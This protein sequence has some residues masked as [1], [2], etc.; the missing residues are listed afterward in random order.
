MDRKTSPI[1]IMLVE[2][3]EGDIF[4]TK[5]AFE[6]AKILNTVS[7]ASN[8]EIALDMLYKRNGHEDAQTPDLIFLDINLPKIDGRQVLAELKGDETLR[9][10][11][12]VILTSSEAEQDVLQSYDLHA[13]S[14]VVKPVD[15]SKFQD[16][17]NAM[18]NFWVKIVKLPPS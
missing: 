6:K 12:V 15:M 14:Y 9:R 4:L 2:D 10:I 7:V 5:K 1:H 13:N 8:G 18:E 3:N 11:P 16:I 17:V